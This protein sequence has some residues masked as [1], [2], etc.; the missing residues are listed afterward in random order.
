MEE[1]VLQNQDTFCDYLCANDLK[2]I[3]FILFS[4]KPILYTDSG[5]QQDHKVICLKLIIQ[6]GFLLCSLGHFFVQ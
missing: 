1:R 5:S 6:F 4:I 2:G 3:Y